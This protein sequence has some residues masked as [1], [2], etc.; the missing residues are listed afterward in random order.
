M[1]ERSANL[2][3]RPAAPSYSLA[4][5]YPRAR[6]APAPHA[7]RPA[8]HLS[9]TV[10][11]RAAREDVRAQARAALRHIH[12]VGFVHGDVALRNMCVDDEGKV[13]F[14]DLGHARKITRDDE[15]ALEMLELDGL[16]VDEDSDD[17]NVSE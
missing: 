2:P 4:L 15:A 11:A 17:M 12:A 14:I 3:R 8:P 9:G 1:T 6:T 5:H 7:S 10:R 16:L 13:L